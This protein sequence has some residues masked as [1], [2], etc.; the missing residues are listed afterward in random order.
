MSEPKSRTKPAKEEAAP[1]GP[2]LR[3]KLTKSII[4]ATD[5][6]QATVRS[7]GLHRMH[8]EVTRADSSVTRGMIHKVKHLVQVTEEA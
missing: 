7:L 5:R 1:S 4:R 6:Q 8:H 3:I 2:L